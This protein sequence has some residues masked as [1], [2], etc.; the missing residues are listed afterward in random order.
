MCFDLYQIYLMIYLMCFDLY[1]MCFDL[2][3][4]YFVI[5]LIY[6]MISN[7]LG[8]G[9]GGGIDTYIL[10]TASGRWSHSLPR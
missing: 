2:Y 10:L 9:M 1:Q 5:Y 8:G 3:L 7:L 4:I 6:L